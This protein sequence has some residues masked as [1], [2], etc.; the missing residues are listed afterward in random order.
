LPCLLETLIY[1]NDFWVQRV[2]KD[3]GR[4]FLVNPT[5]LLGACEIDKT[6]KFLLTLKLDN[7]PDVFHKE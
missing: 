4:R 6:E 3:E 7:A 2:D 1:K 5:A